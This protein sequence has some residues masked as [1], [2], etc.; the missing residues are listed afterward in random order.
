MAKS[1]LEFIQE[2][3]DCY[4]AMDRQGGQ[5]PVSARTTRDSKKKLGRLFAE[6]GRRMGRVEAGN[7]LVGTTPRPGH[8]VPLIKMPVPPWDLEDSLA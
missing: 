4:N 1:E 2:I 7:A 6:H 5:V 3:N 8:R